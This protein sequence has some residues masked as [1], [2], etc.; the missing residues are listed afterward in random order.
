MLWRSSQLHLRKPNMNFRKIGSVTLRVPSAAPR[1]G[2]LVHPRNQEL[3]QSQGEALKG[4]IGQGITL[5]GHRLG[6]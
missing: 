6:V 2:A 4:P 3:G 1:N 5:S